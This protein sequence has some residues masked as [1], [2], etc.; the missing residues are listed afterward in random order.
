MVGGCCRL[1]EGAHCVYSAG[2]GGPVCSGRPA[3]TEGLG[4]PGGPEDWTLWASWGENQRRGCLWAVSGKVDAAAAAGEEDV[5]GSCS[6][7]S[8][9]HITQRVYQVP[10]PFRR[11]VGL[12]PPVDI[13]GLSGE[14][15]GRGHPNGMVGSDGVIGIDGREW[16][17][18]RGEGF[19]AQ[20]N[21][22]V[23]IGS[24]GGE[25]KR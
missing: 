17:K 9:L 5:A 15:E 10:M 20:T 6:W 12:S 18:D 11:S 25:G 19:V 1:I 21:A 7:P 14:V 24:G 3:N 2:S 16:S 13:A 8:G 23:E 4:G 22:R